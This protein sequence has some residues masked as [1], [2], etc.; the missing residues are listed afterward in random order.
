[1]IMLQAKGDWTPYEQITY[2]YSDGSLCSLWEDQN[3]TV[4]VCNPVVTNQ[5]GKLPLVFAEPKMPISAYTGDR[6]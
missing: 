1:M 2:R 4:P 3:K 5:Y 6:R